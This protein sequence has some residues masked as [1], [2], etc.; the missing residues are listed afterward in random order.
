MRDDGSIGEIGLGAL[1]CCISKSAHLRGIDRCN[2]QTCTSKSS[3][4]NLFKSTRGLYCNASR[5]KREE[6]GDELFNALA[7]SGNA[8]ALHHRAQVN[9]QTVL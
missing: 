2:R 1:A 5:C 4:D 9:I 8:K 7:I 3:D 6:S